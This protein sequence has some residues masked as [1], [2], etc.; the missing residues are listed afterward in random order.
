MATFKLE[1]LADAA[2]V[3]PRTVRY[4]VQRGLLPPPVFRGRDT[5]YDADHLV[6]LR[7]IRK[8]QEA[9]LP[10]D[11]IQAQL[12]NLT[13]LEVKFIADQEDRVYVHP[14]KTVDLDHPNRF[15]PASQLHPPAHHVPRVPAPEPHSESPAESPAESIERWVLAPGLEL[16]LS[17]RASH[18][19]RAL[20][21]EL[22]AWCRAH[23]R[24]ES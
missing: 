18:E 9:F 6:R 23:R 1:E 5:V 21:E 4:Y 24:G 10:L 12:A 15:V 2:G 13:P 8:L 14:T 7:A 16:Q 19:T 20:A 3:S 22:R 17:E 11:T